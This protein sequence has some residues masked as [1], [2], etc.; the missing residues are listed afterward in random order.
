MVIERSLLISLL[1]LTKD[2]FV[3]IETVKKDSRIDADIVR[4]LLEKL[5]NE[6]LIHLKDVTVE[7]NSANRLKLA[8]KAASLGADIEYVSGFFSWQEFE[9]IVALALERNGYVVAKNVRFKRAGRRWEIDVVGCRKPLVLCVDCKHW[10]REVKPSAL[11]KIVEA[12][13]ERTHAL[14]N[15]LPNVNWRVDCVKW[16]KAKFVPVI[17]SLIPSRSKFYE[18]VPVVP[19][20]QLQDFLIQLPAQV[21]SLT[22]FVKEFRHL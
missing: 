19:V 9:D 10:Q 11:R 5:Q 4:K 7:T 15:T 8:V 2:G 20:L 22:Y 16:K 1:K 21:E 12:Q 14:A 17:L 13:V 6:G 18:N 3:L